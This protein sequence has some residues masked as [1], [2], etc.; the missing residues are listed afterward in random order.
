MGDN[1]ALIA[2]LIGGPALASVE[3]LLPLAFGIRPYVSLSQLG[4]GFGLWAMACGFASVMPDLRAKVAGDLS[5]SGGGAELGSSGFAD[6]ASVVSVAVVVLVA[7][8]TRVRTY[9]RQARLRPVVA[10]ELAALREL[11]DAERHSEAPAST[12]HW[13]EDALDEAG[14]ALRTGWAEDAA[15]Y[16]YG[17][18]QDLA[19][20]SVLK[21]VR[22]G[23]CQ[24]RD[25][26]DDATG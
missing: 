3:F 11:V 22:C 20:D 24:I 7:A 2:V 16:I 15:P 13:A 19:E 26:L 18:A 8:A 9:R 25:R 14:D 4:G 1:A 17:A 21:D 6:T 12:L 23:A 5:A 10:A